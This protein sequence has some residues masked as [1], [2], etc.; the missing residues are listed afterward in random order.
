M[1]LPNVPRVLR[2]I[3]TFRE[4]FADDDENDWRERIKAQSAD[5]A[6]RP[7]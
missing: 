5:Y 4:V 7:D 3:S 6:I 2:M 1:C